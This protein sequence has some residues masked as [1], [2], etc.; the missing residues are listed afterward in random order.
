VPV[1]LVLAAAALG[2]C[3]GDDAADDDGGPASTTTEPPTTTTAP[4]TSVTLA[5][6][7]EVEPGFRQGVAR[8]DGGWIFSAND[9]LFRT[10]EQLVETASLLPA[11][12]PD[13]AAQGYDHIGDIDVEDGV[14]YAPFEKPDKETGE[15]AMARYDPE[16]LAFIDAA[17]VAQHHASFVTVDPETMIAYSQDFFGGDTLLRYDLSGGGWEPLEPL[18]LSQLVDRVQGGDVRDGAIYLSTDDDKDGVPYDGVYRVDLESGDV[19]DLGSVGRAD[20]EGE[21]ID[22]TPVD[23]PLPTAGDLHV[24]SIDPDLI[25]VWFLHLALG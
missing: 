16:T 12:P 18:A 6:E 11:I 17:P 15:Q 14:L 9:A 3:A 1:L 24:Q 23:P 22:A 5:G 25:R 20:G 21:G 7:Q 13:W 2:A 4:P 8:V 10:D 19:T